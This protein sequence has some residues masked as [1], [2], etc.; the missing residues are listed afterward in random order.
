MI[1]I[2]PQHY[3]AGF[4]DSRTANDVANQLRIDDALSEKGH[5]CSWIALHAPASGTQNAAEVAQ[6]L[7]PSPKFTV[8]VK[9]VLYEN[10]IT[11]LRRYL[12]GKGIFA[13]QHEIDKATRELQTARDQESP[14]LSP[15]RL[16]ITL[17]VL[18]LLQDSGEIVQ[19]H[20]RRTYARS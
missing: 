18:K 19:K 11:R 15:E 10:M 14:S 1:E 13:T 6:C 12:N 4:V 2:L 8:G 5:S 7:N 20:Q 9:R 16:C 3:E 17:E